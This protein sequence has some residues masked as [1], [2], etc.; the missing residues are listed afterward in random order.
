MIPNKLKHD[1]R[2]DYLRSLIDKIKLLHPGISIG[3]IAD[4]LAIDRSQ[5]RA[6]LI[7][8]NKSSYRECP[9]VTQFAIEQWTNTK[10]SHASVDIDLDTLSD[11]HFQ[12][13]KSMHH[14]T[15]G[16][17]NNALYFDVTPTGENEYLTMAQRNFALMCVQHW[18]TI[19][20]A[21]TETAHYTQ[22]FSS[23][24]VKTTS[25]GDLDSDG[26]RLH[27]QSQMSMND[28]D[29]KKFHTQSHD[30]RNKFISHRDDTKEVALPDL[31]LNMLQCFALR[32]KLTQLL[33]F[34]I[35]N[36][37]T[38]Q[39]AQML[40]DYYLNNGSRHGVLLRINKVIR[41]Y[42]AGIKPELSN[43]FHAKYKQLLTPKHC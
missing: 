8:D 32:D 30:V 21:R 4:T 11:Y 15:E 19:F 20:G 3:K 9:Y 31:D 28:S 41:E 25:N 38:R 1:P 37:D 5:F 22:L 24:N 13:V 18:S 2:P 27:F 42:N 6:Y 23:Q 12:L 17:I 10:M 35:N 39:E 33:R 43:A 7:H 14:A 36:G 34:S 29:Y 40:Y 26:V 16:C